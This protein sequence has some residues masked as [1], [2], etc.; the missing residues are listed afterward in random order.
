VEPSHIIP[1]GFPV[2]LANFGSIYINGGYVAVGPGSPD[3]SD[4]Q[5]VQSHTTVSGFDGH[6]GFTVTYS[7]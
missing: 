3:I 6:G 4:D 1:P 2:P 7:R 5:Y